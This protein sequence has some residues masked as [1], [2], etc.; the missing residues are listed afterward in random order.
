MGC[1]LTVISSGSNDWFAA[2]GGRKERPWL[3][4]SLSSSFIWDS[5]GTHWA[6]DAERCEQNQGYF[7]PGECVKERSFQRQIMIFYII[8]H[9]ILHLLHY[10]IMQTNNIKQ[11]VC[12]S[13]SAQH[14]G[15]FPLLKP[16]KVWNKLKERKTCIYV[17]DLLW[18][19]L[20]H[21]TKNIN[22]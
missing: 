19:S 22:L 18:K 2:V 8:I 21:V 5:T 3:S 16:Q 17:Y 15:P 20:L 9:F 10:W 14:F 12:I 11:D 1:E 4:W 6:W 13:H 7:G